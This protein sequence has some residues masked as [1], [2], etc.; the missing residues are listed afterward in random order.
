MQKEN[1]FF[2]SFPSAS[3]FGKA[4][5]TKKGC[6]EQRKHF[7]L[8]FWHIGHYINEDMATSGILPMAAKFLRN[9]RKQLE[10]FLSPHNRCPSA[11]HYRLLYHQ[12]LLLTYIIFYDYNLYRGSLI[13]WYIRNDSHFTARI[14]SFLYHLNLSG[15]AFLQL[16]HMADNSHMSARF[17]MQ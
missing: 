17:G 3:N 4:K 6:K 15:D 2:F 7:D 11:S 12:L 16:F 14:I 8:M 10:A 13:S 9:C 5:V 1:S